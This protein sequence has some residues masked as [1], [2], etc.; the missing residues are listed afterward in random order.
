MHAVLL[1]FMSFQK[2]MAIL[3]TKRKNKNK[4]WKNLI[5]QNNFKL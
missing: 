3:F 2:L 4:L 5:E 1:L